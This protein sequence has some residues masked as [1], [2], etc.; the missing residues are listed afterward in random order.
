MRFVSGLFCIL[1][2]PVL[3]LPPPEPG[4]GVIER[5]IEREY[6]A[7]PLPLEKEIPSVEVDIPEEKLFLPPGKRI[8]I[9]SIEFEGNEAIPSDEIGSWIEDWLEKK[10]TILDIYKI[11]KTIDQRYA[12]RGYFL[13]R[14]Y[15]PPQEIKGGRLTVRILEGRIGSIRI[16]GN[17]HYGTCFIRRYFAPFCNQPLQY[18]QFLQALLLLNENTDLSAGVLFEKGKEVGTADL[19]VRVSDARP[20]HLYF[21]ENN[22]GRK[23]TTNSQLGGRF[24]WGNF[25]ID[26]DTLSVAEVI[27]FPMQALYFTDV[28]YN[29]PL[30]AKGLFME[31]AYLFSRFQIEEIRPLKLAGKSDIGTLK[32]TQAMKRTKSLSIDVFGY[33]DYK[34]IQNYELG[35][36]IS[37]DRL[38]VLTGGVLFDHYNS[39]RGRDYLNFRIAVG[40][41][42]FLGGMSAVSS[43]SSRV[44]GGGRFVKMNLDYDRIQQIYKE[45]MLYFHASGQWSPNKLTLP[46]Q[47]Y[48]GGASSVRGYPLSVALGDS[49]YYVNLETRIPPPI[50]A[51]QRFF[52]SKKKWKEIFQI[53][54]FIDT[55]GTIFNG[56]AHNF[57]TGA[58]FGVRL[59]GPYTISLS[60][61]LGFPLN[62]PDLSSGAFNYLKLTAQPF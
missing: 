57:I 9:E 42:N 31:L 47:I 10:L 30:N 50:L 24:D 59:T 21:N 54:G 52:W 51:Q 55:G 7:K 48:I 3:A 16:E 61:D 32:F 22:Y 60:F 35:K 2:V 6:E 12:E 29:A 14:A 15:P 20:I 19:I 5:E 34:Q 23:L 11:C 36:R 37:F 38:R 8:S 17:K 27:G 41:P 43:Q 4:A 18:D 44:G 1:S 62:R 39:A 49:G 46:E 53:V 56:G 40:I 26:G 33:F 45:W 58:G 13:A 25:S 28:V